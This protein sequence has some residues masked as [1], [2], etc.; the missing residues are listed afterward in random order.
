MK[1]QV[2][3]RRHRIIKTINL[4][5]NHK[6][7]VINKI[8]KRIVSK[9][10]FKV[11]RKSSLAFVLCKNLILKAQISIITILDLIEKIK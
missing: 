6:L 8:F 2:K 1:I 3:M 10:L 5:I 7:L 4:Q 11:K 9:I